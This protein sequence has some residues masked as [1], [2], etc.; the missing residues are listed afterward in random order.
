MRKILYPLTVLL[1]FTFS[2]CSNNDKGNVEPNV[3]NLSIVCGNQNIVVEKGGFE[4]TT[5]DGLFNE[6]SIKVDS[7][8]PE[9]IAANMEGNT[10]IPESELK[11]EF[12]EKPKEVTVIDWSESKNNAYIFKDNTISVP[13]ESGTYIYEII[14]KWAEGQVSYTIKIIIN[15]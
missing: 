11:L 5:K 2:G 8:S 10:V 9:Q 1:L 13:K 6:K 12:S 14:G 3:P 4:W 15:S 7:A